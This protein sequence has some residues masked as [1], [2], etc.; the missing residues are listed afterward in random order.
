MTLQQ[1][2]SAHYRL[3]KVFGTIVLDTLAMVLRNNKVDL[4]MND[5]E[6]LFSIFSQSYGKELGYDHE[7]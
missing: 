4:R 5:S 3:G 6:V 7:I 2:Y 1:T